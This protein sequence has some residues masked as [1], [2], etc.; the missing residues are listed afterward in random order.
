MGGGG[1]EGAENGEEIV[2]IFDVRRERIYNSFERG[3]DKCRNLLSGGVVKK[4]W[5]DQDCWVYGFW[6]GGTEWQ[7]RDWGYGEERC[8][9]WKDHGEGQYLEE[10]KEGLHKDVC[11]VIREKTVS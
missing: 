5:G 9:G 2:S 6:G 8:L 1:G 4:Q 10:G 7:Y 11:R 3:V